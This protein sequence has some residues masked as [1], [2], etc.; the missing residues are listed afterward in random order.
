MWAIGNDYSGWNT[1]ADSVVRA[2][3]DGVLAT[4]TGHHPMTAELYPTPKLS[5]DA[6]EYRSRIHFNLCYT[7]APPYVTVKRGYNQGSGLP[8]ILFECIYE[9]DGSKGNGRHGY[10]G[11]DRIVRSTLHWSILSGALAPNRSIPITRPVRPA[12]FHHSSPRAASTTATGSAG[13]IHGTVGVQC[14]QTLSSVPANTLPLGICKTSVRAFTR[15][16][17]TFACVPTFSLFVSVCP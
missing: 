12:S 5:W 1:P 9:D 8:L 14:P 15:R 3:M 4:D 16:Q 7:Y 11:T 13:G 2:F 10:R 17:A 6:P